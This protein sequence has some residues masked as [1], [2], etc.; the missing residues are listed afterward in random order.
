MNNSKFQV[1][2]LIHSVWVISSSTKFFC[3]ISLP[4]LEIFANATNE[5][6]NNKI[7]PVRLHTTEGEVQVLTDRYLEVFSFRQYIGAIDGTHIEIA[8]LA[9]VTTL[10]QRRC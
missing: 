1:M 4:E 2:Y 7:P 5:T 8:Q 10:S 3:D 6:S 9:H